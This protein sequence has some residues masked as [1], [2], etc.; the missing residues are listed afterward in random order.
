MATK[1]T[2]PA[3]PDSPPAASAG[4][5]AGPDDAPD[6]GVPVLSQLPRLSAPVD[7]TKT[8][9]DIIH[10]RSRGRFFGRRSLGDRLPLEWI[11]L[12]MLVAIA[13]L[14]AVLKLVF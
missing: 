12:A 8:V 9:P 6:E 11:S 3:A 4:A 7:L 5:G 2:T 14:Y 1:E 10:R 13:I